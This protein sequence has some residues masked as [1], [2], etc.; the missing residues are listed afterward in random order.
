MGAEV[1]LGYGRAHHRTRIRCASLDP[2]AKYEIVKPCVHPRWSWPL[3]AR[4]GMARVAMPAV[5][6]LADV[7]RSAHQALQAMGA[8]ILR[9]GYLEARAQRLHGAHIVFDK[10]T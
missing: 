8:E 9:H 4:T 2:V 10:I 5:A 1:E 3:V 7:D 6:P